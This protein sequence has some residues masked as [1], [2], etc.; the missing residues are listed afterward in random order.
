MFKN[1]KINIAGWMLIALASIVILAATVGSYSVSRNIRFIADSWENY[2]TQKSPKKL[3]LAELNETIGYGGLIHNFKNMVLRKDK[4]LYKKIY[5]NLGRAQS[6]IDRY[7]LTN[8]YD[9]E[10][11]ALNNIE[12]MLQSYL[13]MTERVVVLSEEGKTSREIDV[14]VKI[15]DTKAK[16]S[17]KILDSTA[18]TDHD[19]FNT[20]PE[21]ILE[22]R[23]EL[24]YG[25][26]IHNFKNFILRNEQAYYQKAL[27][28][29][30]EVTELL[31]EYKTKWIQPS[32]QESIH[33]IIGIT[34]NY[35]QALNQAVKLLANG[36]TPEEIDE[37]LRINDQSAL[38][39]FTALEE[40]TEMQ[41]ARNEESIEHNLNEAGFL[42][43][44]I[45]LAII[46]ITI[47]LLIL[48]S[49]LLRTQIIRPINQVTRTMNRLLE[50]DLSIDKH[51]ELLYRGDNEI[52]QMNQAIDI[53]RSNAI[54]LAK[55]K[56]VAERSKQYAEKANNA[57][58]MFLSKMSHELRTP[59]NAILGFSQ[60]LKLD[61][62]LND[63][64]RSQ[65][66]DIIHAGDHLLA[67]INDVLDLSK[68]EA[69][70]M[71]IDIVRV[72]IKDVLDDCSTYISPLAKQY[73]VDINIEL[74]N[75]FQVMADRTRLKQVLLN[76]ISNAAKYNK[77]GGSVSVICIEKVGRVR[78]EVIDTGVGLTRADQEK[79]FTSFE[80]MTDKPS[81]IEGTGIGL[82]IAKQLIELMGGQIGVKS[83][84]GEGST[85]WIELDCE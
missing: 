28:G 2:R 36:K 76:F 80:R 75:N 23:E 6:V 61:S 58:S 12:E 13:N 64:Q 63:E 47:V 5:G 53:F 77:P 46:S 62:N 84:P 31:E 81:E 50:G 71:D 66:T 11:I 16:E 10:I 20:R 44:I 29:F 70:K 57:K 15:D 74:A 21:L 32:E 82:V 49:W 54:D 3:L 55:A 8:T 22:I 83:N 59:L 17:L 52:G 69:G 30:T 67:L 40:A 25:G 78:I 60:L 1:M 41:T 9:R 85:F 79:L 37:I 4:S 34:R 18:I 24:G 48:L 43:K 56:E 39:A 42:V 35:R 14:L 72:S 73:D 26:A 51:D 38:L 7:R 65:I 19:Q 68:I 45:P 27:H 33:T